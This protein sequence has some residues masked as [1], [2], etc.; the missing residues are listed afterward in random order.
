[1]TRKNNVSAAE[2]SGFRGNVWSAFDRLPQPIRRALHEAIGPWDPR[3]VRWSLNKRLKAGQEESA[4]VAVEIE[5]IRLNDE[6][7]VNAFQHRWPS[8]FGKYPH[9]AAG[10]T[11]LR[12]EAMKETNHAN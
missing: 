12:Y 1:M 7:E 9:V 11:I 2:L 10:A 5:L 3:E 8:R 4:A 6:A